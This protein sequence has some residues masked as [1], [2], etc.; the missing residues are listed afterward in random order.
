MQAHVC[1]CAY[2]PFTPRSTSTWTCTAP[3]K[4]PGLGRQCRCVCKR[5]QGHEQCVQSAAA[6]RRCV[7]TVKRKP[8][9][10]PGTRAPLHKGG[11]CTCPC[12]APSLQKENTP[13]HR[14]VVAV[15]PNLK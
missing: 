1:S 14:T 15:K 13:R 7:R 4:R 12:S 2:V 8:G 11:G 10:R 9:L 5:G 6:G 3:C